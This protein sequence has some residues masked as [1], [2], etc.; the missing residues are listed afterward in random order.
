MK[1]PM[2]RRIDVQEVIEVFVDELR[3]LTFDGHQ[4]RMEFDVV[5]KDATAPEDDSR[6]W[7]YTASRLVMSA[8]GVAGLLDQ[9]TRLKEALNPQGA[10]AP[11][12]PR[13]REPEPVLMWKGR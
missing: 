7:V 11:A 4:L 8:H 2:P 12:E 6:Q 13:D 9:M 1:S 3:F 10:A 5:R